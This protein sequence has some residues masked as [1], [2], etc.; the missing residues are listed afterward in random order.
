M[1]KRSRNKAELHILYVLENYYPNI[2][3]VENLFKKLVEKVAEEG[4]RVT[5]ITTRLSKADPAR[6]IQGNVQ[7]FR[8]R[9]FNRYFFT[10]LALF[11]VL[12]HAGSCDLIH[13]TSYNAAFP[14]FF[15]ALLRRKKIIITFH[16]V[17]A[18]QWFK[19]PFMSD[20]GKWLH[21][22]FEQMLLRLSFDCF[23]GVSR[24]TA[25][26]LVTAGIDPGNVRTIY[27]GIDYQDFIEKRTDGSVPVVKPFTY[28]YFGR[29]GVSKGLDILLESAKIYRKQNPN[30]R[31]K[32]IIPKTPPSFFALILSHIEKA[33]LREY[34]E[35][36][37]HLS[38]GQLKQEL[39]DS[40]CVVVP[41]LSEG[42]CFAAVESIAL[43]V[44]V[45]SSDQGALREV[46]SGKFI[47]MKSPDA[48]SL[49][50]ALDEARADNWEQT[51]VKKFELANTVAA[52][53]ALYQEIAAD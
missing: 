11:P 43:G 7:I 14:A 12:R 10:L 20:V 18:S 36:R 15:G 42:F 22:L 26:D 39:L 38:F 30:S 31:L 1:M 5:L 29:L 48:V 52:Y 13:T 32:M 51:P 41:S 34:V 45:I 53:L 19:L 16:E 24:S 37:H 44:P 27:N 49:V 50:E 35:L 40:D 23:V 9:F 28:T 8:Y 6:E 17:W 33:G 46:V 3:G 4:H 25:E 47:K 2:G 21:Y